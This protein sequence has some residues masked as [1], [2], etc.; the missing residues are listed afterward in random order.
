M[1]KRKITNWAQWAVGIAGCTKSATIGRFKRGNLVC[2]KC[3]SADQIQL[4]EGGVCKRCQ[5]PA[6]RGRGLNPTAGKCQ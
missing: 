3:G 1:S 5:S 4:F 6:S 2:K